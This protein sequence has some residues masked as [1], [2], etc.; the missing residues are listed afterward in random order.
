MSKSSDEITRRELIKGA[1]ALTA[2][3]AIFPQIVPRSVVGGASVTPPSETLN[4]AC[5]GLGLMGAN[6]VLTAK[7]AGAR[8]V[9]LCEADETQ[10]TRVY[11]ACPDAARYTDFRRMLEK[12]KGI[13]AVMVATPDHSH[14]TI[15]MAAMELGKHVYCEKPLAHTMYE[16][17]RMMQAAREY[18]VATQMGNQGHSYESCREFCECI[19]S[20][21]IGEVREIHVVAAAFNFSLID[22]LPRLAEDH[23]VPE[24]LDWNL[25]L[26]P[27]PYRK[28]HPLY[29]PDTWRC[30]QQ[31]GSGMLGD[32]VCHVV[33]PVFLALDL[34]A[35][36]SVVA[37]AEGY[38]IVKHGETFPKSEK[39]RFEFPARGKR[40]PVTL[41]WYDGDH[42]AA[43][44]PEASTDGEKSSPVPSWAKGSPANALVVGDKGQI[45]YA[46]HGAMNWRILSEAKMKEYLGGRTPASDP[47]WPNNLV[48][49]EDWL[50]ACKGWDPA[51]SNFDYAGPLTEIAVL[52]NIAQHL[53]GTELKWDAE[54]MTFPNAPKANQFLHFRYRDGWAL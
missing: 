40:P 14:A 30:W 16:V 29:H 32:Y 39:I 54:H 25:W 5:I 15:S 53:P 19:W 51:G 38:D 11:R 50:Q 2:A 26:G 36:V 12:E 34:G 8:I 24:T 21:A 7:Q 27:A 46:S 31:F 35:P 49:V 42:Y 33:D 17:R 28:Y 18:K 44:D 10:G 20:G 13:D 45:V 43:P 4:V 6:D 1:A 41:Y 23:P 9:A 48:H 22:A 3:G 37:E 52:G 47:S